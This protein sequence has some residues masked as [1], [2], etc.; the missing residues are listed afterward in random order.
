MEGHRKQMPI[1]N[2]MMQATTDARLSF[3]LLKGLSSMVSV[4]LPDYTWK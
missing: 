3:D 2:G 1:M 4:A